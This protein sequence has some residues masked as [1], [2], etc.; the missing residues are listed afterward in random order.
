MKKIII[1][2]VFCFVSNL[3]FAQEIHKVELIFRYTPPVCNEG[4]AADTT[5][6]FITDRPLKNTKFYV[7]KDKHC[8]DSIITDE[9]GI[10]VIKL[11]DGEFF[12]FEE[13]KQFK[14]TPD[15]SPKSDFFADCLVKV[16]QK[17]NYKIVFANDE[18]TMTYY[19]VSASRCPDA[20]ACLKV[21]HLPGQIKRN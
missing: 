17:P 7:Y 3:I 8:I 1:V 5:K 18:V 20:Y 11:T 12:L 4:K 21:R 9:E 16:W 10:V 15:G 2:S 19:E 13:W 6:M 14:R